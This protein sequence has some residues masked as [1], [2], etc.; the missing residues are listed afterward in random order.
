MKRG[1]SLL[2]VVLMIF[3]LSFVFA[4]SVV[5]LD[6]DGYDNL[7]D[8]DDSSFKIHPGAVEITDGID[9]DCDAVVD[10]EN[11]FVVDGAVGEEESVVEDGG[12]EEKENV[13]ETINDIRN[14]VSSRS[15]IDGGFGPGDLLHPLDKFFDSFQSGLSTLEERAA[16]MIDALREGDEDNARIALNE[17]RDHLKELENIIDPEQKNKIK[18]IIIAIDDALNDVEGL[19]DENKKEF[20]GVLEGGLELLST[21][22]LREKVVALCDELDSRGD[23]GAFGDDGLCGGGLGDSKWAND[24]RDKYSDNQ[25]R[26]ADLFVRSIGACMEDPS[27]KQCDC[28]VANK[29]FELFCNQ[30]VE[31]EKNCRNGNNDACGV[32]DETGER[33]YQ[34]LKDAPHLLDALKRLEGEFE[35]GQEERFDD[36]IPEV[37][38]KLFDEKDINPSSP[39]ARQKCFEVVVYEKAP[40]ECLEAL[41]EGELSLDGGEFA[42]R[43]GCEEIF[44]DKNRENGPRDFAPALG[45]RCNEIKNDREKRLDCFDEAFRTARDNFDQRF[46]DHRKDFE[47]HRNR[48]KD[49]ENTCP[50]EDRNICLKG[51]G[52]W[53]CRDGFV[54]CFY[55]DPDNKNQIPPGEG[56]APERTPSCR[57]GTYPNC[58]DGRFWECKSDY[59]NKCSNVFCQSG[60]YC[61]P[62]TGQCIGGYRNNN[63]PQ[64]YHWDT[65]TKIQTPQGSCVPNCPNGVATDPSTGE[66]AVGSGSGSGDYCGG[67]SRSSSPIKCV[68]GDNKLSC[69][70]NA[71]GCTDGM[72]ESSGSG[73]NGVCGN[74]QCDED[75]IK[76]PSDCPTYSGSTGGSGSSTSASCSS[77]QYWDGSKCITRSP[78]TTTTT[79]SSGSTSGTTSV[80]CGPG[81]HVENGGCVIDSSTS[82][83]TGA[84]ITGKSVYDNPFLK[85]YF[86]R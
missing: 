53:D 56:C 32:A 57:P 86:G 76:C 29:E 65:A 83:I 63:C 68:N 66:C 34:S 15:L 7:A 70:N 27:S 59:Q 10:E 12:I 28:D 78:E 33:V 50:I 41:E 5:D 17:Y 67:L 85:Y 55:D 24:K 11:N 42:F 77:E 23:F 62:S 30:I 36:Y 47:D 52:R 40:P 1:W 26:E 48:F 31:A 69:I 46:E 25:N 58:K 84:V 2:L 20:G 16:E 43:R 37:C 75:P 60:S 4:Q 35:R 3:S 54:E 51:G 73:S 74:G 81:Y 71:W 13:K 72:S 18:E 61:D 82:G 80:S 79:T 21:A 14:D 8:C 45:L 38:Q 44:K 64:G 9:N 6:K 49:F 22:E 19:N 39:D